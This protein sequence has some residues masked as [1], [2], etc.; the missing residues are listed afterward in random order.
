MAL[1]VLLIVNSKKACT[2]L[3]H[4]LIKGHTHEDID[5]IFGH[6]GSTLCS[7]S[8]KLYSESH[9]AALKKYQTRFG[10]LMKEIGRMRKEGNAHRSVIADRWAWFCRR[11]AAA[12]EFHFLCITLTELKRDREAAL[13]P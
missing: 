10:H 11:K 8:P 9:L 4:W 3:V 5:A 7:E 2:M 6:L 13:P 12:R 1:L